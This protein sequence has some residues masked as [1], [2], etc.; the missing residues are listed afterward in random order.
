M[1]EKKWITKQVFLRNFY[2]LYPKSHHVNNK[3]FH[4]LIFLSFVW[5][6]QSSPMNLHYIFLI[7]SVSKVWYLALHFF[8]Y[9]HPARE[10]Q[11]IE[12][13]TGPWW[14]LLLRGEIRFLVFALFWV[15]LWAKLPPGTNGL[16]VDIHLVVSPA[17]VRSQTVCMGGL[18]LPQTK[19]KS[20]GLLEDII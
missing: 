2:L 7:S 3:Y 5:F 1:V 16:D 11:K 13:T 10:V 17:K 6:V 4:A 9:D 14:H 15:I 19:T 12:T 20:L 18:C 8:F